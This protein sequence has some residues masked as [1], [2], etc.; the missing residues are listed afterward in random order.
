MASG[1]TTVADVVVPEVFT[2]YVQVLTEEKSRIINSG[3]VTRDE[4]LDEFLAGGGLTKHSPSFRD[5]DNDSENISTSDTGT[6]AP[7]KIRTTQEIVVRLS[8][9]Q[10]WSSA[11]LAAA[12][13]GTDPMDA[14]A[15]RV[16]AYWIRRDQLIL[17][18]T[19][20]GVFA[21]NDTATDAYHIQYDLTHDVSGASFSDGVTNFTAES[22]INTAATMGDSMDSLAMMFVHSIVYTRMQKLNLIDYIVDSEGKIRIPV[23]QNKIVVVDDGMPNS[24]GVFQ[25]WLF[26]SGALRMGMGAPK[27]PTEVERKASAGNGG[28]QEVLYSRLERVLHPV[29]HAFVGTAVPE[30]GPSN[31][32]TSGNLAN[33][34]SWQRAF[35]ERK[36]IQMARL[37]TREF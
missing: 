7:K 23:Y 11:D 30:G 26:G 19:M 2:P 27:V 37:V 32:S 1:I 22:V 21:N 5:L 20:A 6:S 13:A 35:A 15:R 24:S 33:A 25:T 12:L 10:S 3:A 28:G 31:A 16:A 29:G 17:M 18:A 34:G 36:Q 8:R 4:S 9:N 14:I